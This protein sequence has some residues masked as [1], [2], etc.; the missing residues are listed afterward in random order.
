MESHSGIMIREGT[1]VGDQCQKMDFGGTG[2]EM[3][4]KTQA[5]GGKWV[6]WVI[7]RM[8]HSNEPQVVEG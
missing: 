5:S 6:D 2:L 7:Q 1:N 8:A 4:P 3:D